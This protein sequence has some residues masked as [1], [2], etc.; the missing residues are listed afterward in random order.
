MANLV[1]TAVIKDVIIATC[2]VKEKI[3]ATAIINTL[4]PIGE[5]CTPYDLIDG[6]NAGTTYVP[7]NGFNLISGGG[8]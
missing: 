3:V 7:I 5:V 4:S 2:S 1:A 8:A 6:G